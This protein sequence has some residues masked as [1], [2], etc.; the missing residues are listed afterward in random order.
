MPRY[1]FHCRRCGVTYEKRL[2][3]SDYSE[4]EGWECPECGSAEEVERSFSAVAFVGGSS[5]G[6]GP[7]CSPR[8]GFT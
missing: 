5:R 3:M 7:A 8:G 2:S 6:S 4:R 1:D